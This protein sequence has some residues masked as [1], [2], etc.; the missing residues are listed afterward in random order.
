MTQNAD[1]A[2][3]HAIYDLFL[4]KSDGVEI[5]ERD[6]GYISAGVYGLNY[7]FSSY[8]DW[9]VPDRQGM[10]YVRGRVLDIGCGAGRVSLYLQKEGH[11]VVAI[12]N[13]SFAVKTARERGVKDVREMSITEIN[14]KMGVF[15]TIVMYGN[16]FGLLASFDQ[17]RHRLKRLRGMTSEKGRI[18]AS[19]GNPYKTDEPEHLNY[20]RRNKEKGRLSGQLRLRIRYKN[21]KG[22]WFDYL[23]ASP[24]EIEKIVDRTGWRVLKVLEEEADFRYV[25]VLEKE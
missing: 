21:L 20:H 6:D 5:V 22:P 18:V 16:N 8:P 15:D 17:A 11:D 10:R 2:Q 24:E 7:Y 12:D 14:T 25:V 9:M 4:G 19:V 1:D 3:G 23:F 13:S